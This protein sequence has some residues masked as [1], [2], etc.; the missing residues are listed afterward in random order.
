MKKIIC[1]IFFGTCLLSTSLYASTVKG[2][3]FYAQ[4]LKPVCGF[5]GDVMGKKYTA[6]EWKTFYDNNQLSL[7]IKALCPNSPLITTEKDLTNLYHFL[8]SFASDSGNV[9]SCN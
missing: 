8:S 7:A 5:N 4:Y 9:P 1:A 6:N 3:V 2:K